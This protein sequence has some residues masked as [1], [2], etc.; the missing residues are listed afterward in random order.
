MTAMGMNY[1]VP[2][3]VNIM[4]LLPAKGGLRSKPLSEANIFMTFGQKGNKSSH[5]LGN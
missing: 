3:T 2:I 5:S 4:M 1:S